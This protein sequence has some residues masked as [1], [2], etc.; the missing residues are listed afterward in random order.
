MNCICIRN[1][2]YSKAKTIHKTHNGI[3]IT[4]ALKIGFNLNKQ[5]AWISK[6]DNAEPNF[7]AVKVQ[8]KKSRC[9]K[10]KTYYNI[11]C[12]SK[13]CKIQSTEILIILLK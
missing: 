5:Q 8:V 12:R 4:A 1:I 2:S 10:C 6:I 13:D 7:S 9:L 11:Q 3:K